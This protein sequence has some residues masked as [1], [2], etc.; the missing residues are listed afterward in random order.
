MKNSRVGIIFILVLIMLALALYFSFFYR[1]SCKDYECFNSNLAK[2]SK[3]TFQ[4]EGKDATWYYRIEGSKDNQ[5]NI[6]TE[7]RQVKNGRPD[8][9]VLEGQSMNCYLPLG[10]IS[11]PEKDISKCHG[12]LRENLL[13]DL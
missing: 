11:S 3:A 13:V 4:A 6:Y 2:C 1:A 9:V 8:L 5:C 12:L 7:L 10:V